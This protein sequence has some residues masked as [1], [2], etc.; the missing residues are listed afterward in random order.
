MRF[1]FFHR[2]RRRTL[3]ALAILFSSSFIFINAIAFMQ[4]RS[5]THFAPGGERTPSPEA[6]SILGKAEAVLLG[7]QIPRPENITDPHSIGLDFQTVRFGGPR[8]SDC[9]AWYIRADNSRGL[10]IQFHAY[11]CSKS[12]LLA[13]AAEF[14][15]LG[16]SLLLVDFRGSG[17]SIGNDTT[18]GYREAEDVAA[19]VQFA[20]TKWNPHPLILYGQSMGGCAILRAVADL[21]VRPTAIIFE[22]TYN[23]LLDAVKERFRS[24]GLPGTPAAQMLVFWG[25]W[26]GGFNGFKVNPDEYAKKVTCPALMFQGGRDPRVTY[27][28]SR[29]LFDNLAGPKQFEFF[30]QS[31]HCGFR[32]QDK[33][34][35][36]KAIV[37]FLA[38]C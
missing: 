22:S 1:K 27:A 4:A 30:P 25:G 35:W 32:E 34:R 12:S 36:I 28:E 15:N 3:I 37:D 24:M 16:Y 31:N 8:N 13:P 17:G 7:V 5:M 33:P 11:T 18:I 6:L 20:Q 14:H 2:P 23:R 9:E 10:C 19:A 26:Q 29:D 38:K 21:N